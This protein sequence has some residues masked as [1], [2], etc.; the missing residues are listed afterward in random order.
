MSE[1]P[2]YGAVRKLL[3]G[4]YQVRYRGVGG[5]LT[6]APETFASKVEAQRWRSFRAGPCGP[7]SPP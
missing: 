6:A 4:R 7:P 3:S 5:R 2:H 1:R